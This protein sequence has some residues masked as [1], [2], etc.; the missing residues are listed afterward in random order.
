MVHIRDLESDGL[1]LVR[2]G[3]ERPYLDV[4]NFEELVAFW[5]KGAGPTQELRLHRILAVSTARKGIKSGGHLL[6]QVARHD[7]I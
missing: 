7:A 5:S 1:F 6:L 3:G 2:V 4:D